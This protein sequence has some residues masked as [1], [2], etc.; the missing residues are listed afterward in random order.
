MFFS[1]TLLALSA[2]NDV[3]V[4]CLSSG[5]ADGLGTI[6]KSELIES[7]RRLGVDRVRVIE[8]PFVAPVVFVCVVANSDLHRELQDSMT[9]KW[10]AARVAEFCEANMEGVEVLITFDEGG[11]SGHPNHISLLHGARE[12][13]KGRGVELWTLRTVG[14][15]RKYAFVLDALWT[16]GGAGERK[17]FVSTIEQVRTAQKA[18]TTAHVSQMR[19]FRWGWIGLSRYMVMNDLAVEG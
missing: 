18:M 17:V 19:W 11:V 16:L 6:R 12:F 13:V 2:T 3:G 10:P 9:K 4:L 1:P 8:H 7:C 14:L 15:V 5:D